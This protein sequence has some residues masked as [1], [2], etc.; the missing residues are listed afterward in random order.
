MLTC[1][2]SYE[3]FFSSEFF[4]D[5]LF[6]P[7]VWKFC[8]LYAGNSVDPFLPF[9]LFPR[10]PSVLFS[11]YERNIFFISGKTKAL[12]WWEISFLFLFLGTTSDPQEKI[13]PVRKLC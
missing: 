9:F 11:S 5:F 7:S 8:D 3:N 6:E 10:C 13:Q 2:S 12:T 1:D 4:V